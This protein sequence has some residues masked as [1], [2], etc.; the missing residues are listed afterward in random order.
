M[1]KVLIGYPLD[2]YEEFKEILRSASATCSMV[3]KDY[4][5]DWLRRH[6]HK[7]D[8]IV[9]SLKVVVDDAIIDNAVNLKLLFTPTTGRDH[10]RI[11]R[12]KSRVKVLTLNDYAEEISS[13]NSTAELGFSFVLSLSRRM[14]AAC[15]DV[16]ES[17]RWERNDFLGRELN[18]KVM[19]ILGMG[20]VGQKM[21]GYADAFGMKVIYWDKAERR[22]WKR[23]PQLNKL[24]SLSDFVVVS[25]AL[26]NA[27]RHLI[28]MDNIGFLKRG[29]FLVNVSRGEV[30]EE[31][32]LG[33]ALQKGILSGV[34]A[35]VLELELEDYTKSPLYKHARSNPG[36]NIIITPH[37]G[38]ATLDAW[39]KV[40]ALVLNEIVDEGTSNGHQDNS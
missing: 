35:D 27:T 30:I 23:I 31:E 29:S 10:I 18:G 26:N 6:V 17:G 8:V 24:L 37:I 40:F 33:F 2:R 14:L 16:A 32:S 15:R 1:K 34:G 28:N 21:A 38:G 9:P 19:G 11:E 7:F 39:K 20:R 22:M 5:Y 13:I 36:A 25:I 4:H 12:N 3:F